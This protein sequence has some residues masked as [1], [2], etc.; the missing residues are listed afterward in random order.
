MREIDPGPVADLKG[1]TRVAN[2][3]SFRE[4]ITRAGV[5]LEPLKLKKDA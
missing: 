2:S 4:A 1:I 5:L 3:V